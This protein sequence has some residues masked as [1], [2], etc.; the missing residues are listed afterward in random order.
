MSNNNLIDKD[1]K[2][3]ERRRKIFRIS[4]IIGAIVSGICNLLEI[5]AGDFSFSD[6]AIFLFCIFMAISSK[7]QKKEESDDER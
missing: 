2:D 4:G 1:T 6:F 7:K 3:I 5:I